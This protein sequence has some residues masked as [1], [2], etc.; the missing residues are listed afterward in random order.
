MIEEDLENVCI[1]CHHLGHQQETDV[2]K[3]VDYLP[4][5][6]KHSAGVPKSFIRQMASMMFSVGLMNKFRK[7]KGADPLCKARQ[8][9]WHDFGDEEEKLPCSHCGYDTTLCSSCQK[10]PI[11][12]NWLCIECKAAQKA[13]WNE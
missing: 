7:A 2:C 13:R 11:E 3:H 9:Y 10:N 12:K 5:C 1:M 8:D 6:A 4:Y